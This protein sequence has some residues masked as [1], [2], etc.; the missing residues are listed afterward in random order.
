MPATLQPTFIQVSLAE[1]RE[2]RYLNIDY[3]E[4]YEEIN[5]I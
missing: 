1:T 4:S 2:L 3:I 5:T